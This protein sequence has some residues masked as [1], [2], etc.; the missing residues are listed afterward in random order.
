[1]GDGADTFDL[2]GK[3]A[4]RRQDRAIVNGLA[5][6]A[7]FAGRAGL[8]GDPHLRQ[9]RSNPRFERLYRACFLGSGLDA[10][11]GDSDF[12][13]L[14]PDFL[15]P[16]RC[17]SDLAQAFLGFCQTGCCFALPVELLAYAEPL[18]P[19][20]ERAAKFFTLGPSLFEG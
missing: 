2:K 10:L 18:L 9:L 19:V 20:I 12:G 14:R 5:S 8:I 3:R 1:D 15:G 6:Y 13:Q 17:A 7:D 4:R 11:I 16:L